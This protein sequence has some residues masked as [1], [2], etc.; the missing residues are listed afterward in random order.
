MILFIILGATT[1]SQI[2]SFSGATQGIVSAILGQGLSTF[3]ILAG[4][5]LLLIFLGIFV[6]QVSMMLITLPV[7]MPIVQRLEIDLIWFGVLYLICMQL[8]LAAAAARAAADDDERRRAAGSNDGAHLS[9]G[10]ALHRD[11]HCA[12]AD[13]H[14]V[15]G[16]CDLAAK[17]FGVR[18]D[19]WTRTACLPGTRVLAVDFTRTLAKVLPNKPKNFRGEVLMY[20]VRNFMLG[21]MAAVAMSA[22]ASVP[23]SA[24]GQLNIYCSVQVE[25]CQGIATNFQRETG[26]TVNMTQK[27]SGETLAQVRAEAQNPRGDIW[28]GG[29]GDPHLAAAEA[30]L[31]VEYK[32]AALNELQPWAI[33]QYQSS[34]GRSVGIYSGAIGF[35]YNTELLAKKNIPAPACWADLIKPVYKA[36]IQVANPSSSGTAYTFIATVI[37][38]MGEDK[39]FEYT[40]AAAPEHQRLRPF[41]NRAGQGG[42]AR[43]DRGVAV[44]RARRRHRKERRFSGCLHHALRRHRL[45]DR[46]DVD[47]QGRAQSEAGAALL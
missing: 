34:K 19:G 36:E 12:S 22:A 23:A 10:R 30:G 1:F 14:R 16:D 6:D 3:A 18:A 40:E 5:M 27:G 45:R 33:K 25:W 29:T 38:L 47:P 20:S 44:L 42:G 15:S 37:Q 28:F 8:G 2:L 35:G 17:P 43:R 24:Q 31:S 46:I 13:H 32:P 9:G 21:A 7:F 11:E 4:M 26:I 39:A 41:R